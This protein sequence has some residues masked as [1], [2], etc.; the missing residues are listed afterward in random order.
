MHGS[1][2]DGGVRV[3]RARVVEGEQSAALFGEREIPAQRAE[4]KICAGA[5]VERRS[6]CRERRDAE[7]CTGGAARH[8]SAGV[9]AELVR[10]EREMTEDVI[11]A[12]AACRAVGD[13]V[14]V[15]AD[16]RG[17]GERDGRVTLE[18][19]RAAAEAER[20]IS[21]REWVRDAE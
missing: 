17:S 5:D 6:A 19:E 16:R 8:A 2:R 4:G 18:R 13:E 7:G 12:R 15:A 3:S 20:S 9:D 21:H 10:G 1:R 14:D 11:H